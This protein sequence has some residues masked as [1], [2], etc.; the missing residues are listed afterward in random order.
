MRL[1]Y[2]QI[3]MYI[4]YKNKIY[5]NISDLQLFSTNIRSSNMRQ[6]YPLTHEI[7]NSRWKISPVE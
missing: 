7:I 3:D 6:R 4:S 2:I 5:E 1:L